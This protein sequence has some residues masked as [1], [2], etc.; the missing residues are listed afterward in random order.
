MKTALEHLGDFGARF[1]DCVELHRQDDPRLLRYVDLVRDGRNPI[2]D[3]VVEDK[4]QALLYVIDA[5]RLSESPNGPQNIAD[6]RRKL[7]MRGDPSWLGVLRPGRLDI[8]ATDLRP[9]HDA[10]PVSFLANQPEA[11]GVLARLAHGENLA[12]PSELLLRSVL[13][14]LMTHASQELKEIGISTDESIALTG[15]ALFFRYLMGR[16]IIKSHHLAAISASAQSLE[17]C[18]AS[19]ESLAETNIWLDRT[20]NGDLLKLP[21]QNYREYFCDLFLKFGPRLTRPLEAILGLD[22]PLAPGASQRP[23]N[24]GELDFD[25]LP[26]GLLSETYEELMCHFDAETRRDTSVYY[27]PS[28]IAEYMVDEAFHRHPAGASARVLDPACGAGVFLVACFRKLAELRFAETGRRPE[29]SALR[30]ILNEQLV[31]F[32]I[33]AH[34]RTLAAL[35]L[36]LTALE[37]DPDPTPVEGLTFKKLEGKVL[38]DV[39][40]PDSDPAII[41]P[42]VG[43]LGEHVSEQYRSTFDLV[44]GNPPW[45]S[46]KPAYAAIDSIFTKR[47]RAVAAQRDLGDISRTYKNPD[48]VTDLPFV[49]GAMDWAKPGG[50][51]ALALAGRWLFKMKPAGFAARS[52]IFRALSITG[53]LNGASIRQTK[54]WPNVDQPFCLLFADNRV[55][56]EGG[57]FVLVSPDDESKLNEKGRMRIDA[58]DAVPIALDLVATQATLIKTLYRGS[59]L[60]VAIVQRIRERA[61]CSLG[62]YW[63]PEHGLLRGQGYQVKGS[64]D[65]SF[66]AG[67]PTLG[68]RYSAHPFVVFADTL[69]PYLPEGLWRP[70]NPEIYKAPL[71]LVREGFKSDRNQGRALLSFSNLAYSESYYGFSAANH[72]DGEFL[73]KYLL[74]LMHSGLFEY[75]SLMT[76]AKFGV[77]RESLQLH[78]VESFPFVAPAYLD[79]SDRNRIDR[80]AASLLARQPGW[81]E[82]DRT[83]GAIYGLG[84]YDQETICD[85]LA[86]RSPF[87]AIKKFAS[88]PVSRL[89]AEQFCT[90][91]ADELS[92]VLTASGYQVHVRQLAGDDR[93]PWR[94]IALSLGPCTLPGA[95]PSAWITHADDLA[96]SRITIIDAHLPVVIVGLLDRHRYWTPTQARLLASD[97]LWEHGALLEERAKS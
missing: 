24:W 47:C 94:F 15:R 14:G 33:N 6:L 5:A 78:D 21:T 11:V 4:A 25:H 8:Y 77:E 55:P 12:P 2:V 29:R 27:T 91:L 41:R 69:S 37:L 49:W 62:E 88:S 31:G 73:A 22:M 60:D 74:V 70:R 17:M 81:T 61:Q 92:G 30:R 66:L 26:I 51:I 83:V 35:A 45:T 71:V 46:L 1:A 63:I 23:L 84:Q 86:T 48:Q 34:A 93:L 89:E 53:I 54:V 3:T 20:F 96:V 43:S 95:L 82:L 16:G 57:Q 85:A 38:I 64:A 76:S 79:A 59:A 32:D 39:A 67:Y 44:I 80:C 50:R 68:A 75:W 13:F 87:P 10:K 52:A 90:R 56:Q 28:H 18:F 58:N 19:E 97:I 36:Y 42:M 65:D 72:P 7:A 9:D 40:D